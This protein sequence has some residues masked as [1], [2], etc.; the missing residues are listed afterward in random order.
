MTAGVSTLDVILPVYGTPTNTYE[1]ELYTR[2]TY[3]EDYNQEVKLEVY[4][5]SGVLE[6]IQIENFIEPDGY[7]E[8]EVSTEIPQRV[9]AYA[10]PD[11]LSYDL[12]EYEIELDGEVYSLPVPVSVLLDDG[13]TLNG[14]SSDDQIAAQYY[15]QV[16][17][18]KNNQTFTTTVS[19]GE[20]FTT[21]P[22]YCWIEAL[23]VGE[24]S[25]DLDGSLPG[26][27]GIGISEEEFLAILDDFGMTY[28]CSDSGNYR[29]Y[30]YNNTSY[31]CACEVTVYVG[32]DSIFEKDTIIEI[33]CENVLD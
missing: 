31:G 1:N 16:T 18:K 29:Y 5:D 21:I 14:E 19:N 20:D 17:L 11:S 28:A 9:L 13:W 22:E 15:G 7:D 4:T 24:Y 6:D 26:G 27:I 2:L 3:Q 10:K 12:S 8:G 32:T 30:T 23:S 33:S 25:L